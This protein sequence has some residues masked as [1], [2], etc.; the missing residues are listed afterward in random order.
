MRRQL[1]LADN[2]QAEFPNL[3][4]LRRIDRNARTHDDQILPPEGQQP[5]PARLD[6]NPFIDQRRDF[7]GQR[8]GAA[9]IRH[10]HLRALPS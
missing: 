4:Q 2:R 9:H 5:M 1:Q 7:F 3:R 10:C 6:R 8:L